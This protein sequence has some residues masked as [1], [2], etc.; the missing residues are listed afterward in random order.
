MQGFLLL[1]L[2][3]VHLIRSSEGAI[4][5]DYTV[6]NAS[7]EMTASSVTLLNLT[8]TSLASFSVSLTTVQVDSCLA[9]YY[10]YDD[11]ETCSACPAGKYST[12]V[13]A[14][15][16]DTCVSCES[17]KYSSTVG[18]NSSATCLNC[19]NA[20]YFA[21]TAGTG[22]GV[23]VA[24]PANSY[25]YMGAK[26]RQAC[27]CS[28]GYSGPN[29][30]PCNLCNQ[31]DVYGGSGGGGSGMDFMGDGGGGGAIIGTPTVWC[32]YGQ[33]NPCPTHST[34]GQGAYSLAQCLCD[35]GYYG[36]TTM[37]GPDL[38]VCQVGLFDFL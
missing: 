33:A 25:S 20:T 16:I 35:P 5:V 24:C 6:L 2:G 4:S 28:P 27:I 37:G 29:G 34:A 31:P 18:A 14:N 10:S 13:T 21:G 22:I 3:C 32:L 12:V 7:L 23:C 38:T 8:N 36:D 1:V 11:A 17:G 30:G 15:S 26:I 19:P 9:G